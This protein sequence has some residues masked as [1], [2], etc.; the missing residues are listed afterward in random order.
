MGEKGAEQKFASAGVKLLLDPMET[1]EAACT[2]GVIF[3]LKLG[4][5]APW[6]PMVA[7]LGPQAMEATCLCACG[8]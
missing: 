3:A 7:S 1:P 5:L 8:M 2:T 4:G 6:T